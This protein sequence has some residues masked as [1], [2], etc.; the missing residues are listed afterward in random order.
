MTLAPV[1]KLGGYDEVGD[2]LGFRL[3]VKMRSASQAEKIEI[4]GI[5]LAVHQHLHGRESLHDLV[6]RCELEW[7]SVNGST[8]VDFGWLG[9][10][11][12]SFFISRNL[13]E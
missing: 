5:V 2:F 1:V 11:S 4:R 12:E 13:A 9:N 6:A 7:H 10:F 3:P 8:G